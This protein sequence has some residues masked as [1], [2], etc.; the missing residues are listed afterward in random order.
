MRELAIPGLQVDI[1][2]ESE[3]KLPGATG[4]NDGD[5]SRL[6]ISHIDINYSSEPYQPYTLDLELRAYVGTTL[7]SYLYAL[8]EVQGDQRSATNL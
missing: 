6:V 1:W 3:A 5:S 7:P 8:D 2:Y 4:V